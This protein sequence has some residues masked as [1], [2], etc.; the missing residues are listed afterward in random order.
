M[1]PQ[2]ECKRPAIT[3]PPVRGAGYCSC[4]V[5]W[6]CPHRASARLAATIPQ[7]WGQRGSKA[8]FQRNPQCP[9]AQGTMKYEN[10]NSTKWWNPFGG[11]YGGVPH[12]PHSYP[13][14]WGPGGLKHYFRANTL[15]MYRLSGRFKMRILGI[16]LILFNSHRQQESVSIFLATF[17][18]LRIIHAYFTSTSL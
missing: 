14:E 2:G 6:V 15:N 5:V 4:R 9:V 16:E 17:P 10:G 1:R 13:Q 3:I 18:G 7:D 12:S 11:G 8:Y